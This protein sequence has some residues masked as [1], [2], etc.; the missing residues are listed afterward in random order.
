MVSYSIFLD[1]FVFSPHNGRFFQY[2][3]KDWPASEPSASGWGS[4]STP[5]N[6]SLPPVTPLNTTAAP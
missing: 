6:I 4:A 3:R 1:H 2:H 5:L